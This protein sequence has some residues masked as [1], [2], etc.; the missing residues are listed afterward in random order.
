M[1]RRNSLIDQ[2]CIDRDDIGNGVDTPEPAPFVPD[3]TGIELENVKDDIYV[4]QELIGSDVIDPIRTVTQHLWFYSGEQ[5]ETT[6]Q[7]I[8]LSNPIST[9]F[10]RNNGRERIIIT[11]ESPSVGRRG[12]NKI[13]QELQ[14]GQKFVDIVIDQW[15]PE[16]V[17]I[18]SVV[19][20][21]SI[22][23]NN[24]YNFYDELYENKLFPTPGL[25]NYYTVNENNSYRNENK[26]YA[27]TEIVSYSGSISPNLNEKYIKEFSKK[28]FDSNI[29]QSITTKMNNFVFDSENM[30]RYD[31]YNL[32]DNK[33]SIFPFYLK[34]EFDKE[35]PN[36]IFKALQDD[37]FINY[38]C[39]YIATREQANDFDNLVFS[40]KND[41]KPLRKMENVSTIELDYG[42]LES[43]ERFEIEKS[44]ICYLGETNKVS[45]DDVTLQNFLIA[46]SNL[47]NKDIRNYKDMLDGKACYSEALLYKV[48]KYEIDGENFQKV[49]SFFLANTEEISKFKM[50][51]T[52]V[53]YGKKYRYEVFS[54]KYVL[55]NRYSYVN[56]SQEINQQIIEQSY[57]VINEPLPLIVKMLYATIEEV[58]LDKPPSPPEVETIPYKDNS[59]ELSFFFNPSAVQY[60]M[61]EV[62][63]TTEE[64]NQ[65]SLVRDSQNLAEN[66]LITFGGD[67]KT[68]KYYIYRIEKHPSS[69]QDFKDRL[70]AIAQTEEGCVTAEYLENLTPNKKYYY[71]FRAVDV[72]GHL[73]P[74]T[75]VRE[76]ELI[77]EGGTVFLQSKVVAFKDSKFEAKTKDVKRYVHIKPSLLQSLIDEESLEIEQGETARD[78]LP[79]VRI[80]QSDLDENVWNKRFKI[81]I[82]S[83]STNKFVDIKFRFTTQKEEKSV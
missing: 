38:L 42:W 65:Y 75:E 69:Y 34:L 12:I 32:L 62:A 7:K 48:D 15:R 54:Y 83:K 29:V 2:Y 66:E 13:E 28:S 79:R 10:Y 71:I 82:K 59:Q 64:E 35:K 76:I 39:S 55:A 20:R 17:N 3:F 77:N 57:D 21:F 80:G 51:D 9:L 74:P 24:V 45:I 11:S 56:P 60:R 22:R 23:T 40:I 50:I 6:E 63:L 47:L 36:K 1:T 73:S 72:H 41:N 61:A 68:E 26:Q 33:E 37:E 49:Q 81:R 19:S 16:T 27:N 8:L 14:Q 5:T 18:N 46:S 4:Y 52:Q 70:Y 43:L 58:V 78:V 25:P 53:K 31:E 67:D 30:S 44:N